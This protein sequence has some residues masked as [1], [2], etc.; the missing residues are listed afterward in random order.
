[1]RRLTVPQYRNSLR[2]LLGLDENLTEALPPDALSKDGFTN[3]AKSMILSP[4][5][6]EAY[7]DI[8]EKALTSASSTN[9]PNP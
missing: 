9:K 4:L 8:A 7:F 1:M 3:N 2:S 5:Q 6:V